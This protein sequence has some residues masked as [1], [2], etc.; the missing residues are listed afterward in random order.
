MLPSILAKQLEKGIGDYIETTFPMTNAPFKGSLRKM[1]ET[2]DSVYHEPYVSVRLPFRVAESMPTCFEAIHPAYIPYV[3]QQTAF[4]RLTGDDG[5]STLIATGTGSGKTECFLYP[6]LEYCYQHRGEPGIKALI[7]YPMNALASD[8]AKRIAELIWTSQ[9]LRGNVTAG[10]YVGGHEQIPSRMMSEDHVITDHDTMLGNPPDI[11][12]TNYKMLDYLLVRPKDAVLWKE[13]KPDTLKYIAVDELHTFDGAQG[14][15]L[16]C[17]LRRLK[18]RLFTPGGY[19]CC[20][21]TSATM[22]SKDNGK[23]ILQYAEEVFGEPFE[24]EAIVTEDRLSPDEFFVGQDITDFTMPTAEQVTELAALIDQDNEDAYLQ[25]AVTAWTDM[26]G[27]VVASPEGR[28]ALGE[29]LMHHSF[30]QS[31]ISLMKGNYHQIQNIIEELTTNYPDLKEMGDAETAV[32]ALLALISHARTGKVNHLRP[33]L[34]VQV[35]LWIRELRRLV[36]K[37]SGKEISYAIAHDLNTHQARQYLPVVNCRDCGATGW[38]S[39]LSER[40]NATINSL[41]AFYN[42]FFKAD[43]KIVMMFPHKHD[44][45][46]DGMIAGR[47]CPDCMHVKIGDDS[48]SR[49]DNCGSDMV[50]VV[51]PNPISTTGSKDH[52]QFVCPFCGSKRG[53]SLMGLRNATEISTELSQIFASKFNDD[54][55]T[56]AFSDNVQDAAHRAGFFNARTWRFGF[57]TAI[58]RHVQNGGAGLSLADFTKGFIKYWHEQFDDE[59]FVS[60]FIAPNMTWMSAYEEMIEKRKFGK[61]A[62]AKKLMGDIEKRISY[63]I[64]L[65]YGLTSRIGRT[66]EKSGCS[67]LSFPADTITEVAGV[68]HE[69]AVNEIGGLDHTETERFA[70][71]VAGYLKLMA[72]NGAF[73]DDAFS[74]FFKGNGDGYLISND[75]VSWMPGRQSGRNTP[76]FIY[77]PGEQSR[78]NYNFDTVAEK[79]YT[80]WIKSCCNEVLLE[81]SIYAAI[82]RIILEE[83]VKSGIVVS[84][85][86]TAEYTIY[87]LDKNKVFI[88]D[89]VAM[90]KCDTCGIAHAVSAENKKFWEN[91]ACIRSACAG[92]FEEDE[93]SRLDYYGKLFSSGDIVRINAREHTGLLERDD[94][95]TLEIDFKRKKDSAQVWDPNVLSC[96]PTLEMGIDIG[97][98]S[99]VILCSMPPAQSQFLQRTGR[100]GRKDGNALTLAIAAARPHDLY[101]YADPLDMIEGNVVPPKI[102]LK[103][104]AV[105]ER[106]FVA[107]CMDSWVKR[108]VTEHSIPKNVSAVLG[109][110]DSH[111]IDVFPFNFLHYV[112]NNLSHLLNSFVQLFAQYLDDTARNELRTFAQGNKLKESPMHIRIL[113]A[114]KALKKQKDSLSQSIKLLKTMVKEL[115]SKPK[116]SSYDEEIKELKAEQ[117]AL[118]NVVNEINKKDIF[119]FLSDEG[120]LPNYAFPESGIVLKAILY[121]KEDEAEEPQTRTR[122]KKSVYEYSRSASAAISEFA[123]NNSF[124]VDGRKLTIDQVDLTSAQS[125]KWRLCPNCSH[126][127]IE[128]AGKDT[129]C[130]PQCGTP[131]WADAGQVRNMLKVQMV[132]SN[133]DYT[134][135]L[136]SDESDD[137][138][139]VFYCKQLLVD[140]DE[141]HDISSAYE[142]DNEDF[143]FGY[144]FVKKATLREI[145]FGESDLVGEKLMVSGIEEVRKGFKICKYCGK[146]Q[147]EHGKDVHTFYCRTRRMQALNNDPFEE[148][149]FLY[150]EF[151]TEALRILIP[152]TTMDAS[153]VRTESFTAAFMLGMKEYFGN[154][155]HLRATVCEVPVPDADYRKQYLVIYDSVPGGTGY[156]KQLMNEQGSLIDIFE[157][158]LQKLEQCSCKED[159]QK[160]GC[161]HCLYAYRQSQNIGNISRSTAIR[162]LKSILSGKDNLTKIEK[163][164]SIPVN[165]L[166]ESELE[167]RFV[168]ALAQMG[169]EKRKVE[170]TK[171]LIND[172]E[173]YILKVNDSS[174][175]IEPQ[176]TLGP[177]Q[178]VSV[179]CKPDFI[180][181]QIGRSDKLPV[182]IFTDGFIYHKD[183]VADDT[184]KREAIR[185][186]GRYRVWTLSWR[187]VQSV[188]H[189]QVDYATPTLTYEK[190]PSGARMYQRIVGNAD[191]LK[192]GKVPAFE[193]LMQYLDAENA[194]T[195][196]KKH[197][198]AYSFSILD[199]ARSTNNLA[200]MDW[201]DTVA[202]ANRQVHFT[203]DTFVHPGTFFGSWIP[204]ST[205]AHFYAYAGVLSE[206]LQEDKNTSISVI[207]LL[208]DRVTN[209]TDKYEQEWNGFWQFFNVMQFNK[210]FVAVCGT[211]LDNHAYIAL[212]YGQ[213]NSSAEDNM[214]T[215]NSG[216]GWTEIREM[217]FDE[218]TVKIANILEKKGISAPEEAGYELANDSG[219]VIAEIELVWIKRKIGYMTE[220][221]QADRDK[222]EDAGWKIFTNV[223]EI[224]SSFKSSHQQ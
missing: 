19:L 206:R 79:K 109:K 136:I 13:N 212:P 89:D 184:L 82:C 166:F 200:F 154:V 135:S 155:D 123:P 64:M 57:R 53:L 38:T 39:I 11:L 21:G 18:S 216:E 142:M 171:S 118:V 163:L 14:T 43:D 72:Q 56:L 175:E 97:D 162:M 132:Y 172:K 193:L 104:S 36:A 86:A 202:K 151:A 121:R 167:R 190:M 137:R 111:P 50:D 213:T 80:E 217:L 75:R 7:I 73:K 204:R 158:A 44:D 46:P 25:A 224:V 115:E 133:M 35:Q 76:R 174:W 55:K 157:R 181:R 146:I 69:R 28:I 182:A 9:E 215:S 2:R 60:F 112:Q 179:Q 26:S 114:F 197:A 120:L 129:A 61:D 91:A 63:E 205:N 52:R 17:L 149:L 68:V 105:L 211:G 71:M 152:A 96:T 66:L 1:L 41:E 159:P 67:C 101:F 49:C 147:P 194:E 51:L 188:F 220:A 74:L 161:Y 54:K 140:V 128:E 3:H 165:S 199:S 62:R 45:Y 173:G 187:D 116:D 8:Q 27:M 58:Q 47:I 141:D 139:N 92:R 100:A 16:A 103:A 196:F 122:Y 169:N 29:H 107:Y 198:R 145:N 219:E 208:D 81:P 94:R 210:N 113:E 138:S 77:R 40:M 223:D 59:S 37:V 99:T 185:R 192:P 148:C 186:S 178:G 144:E 143:A 130:C 32:N 90:M 203:E 150:R 24:D 5:R 42:R 127:Q 180:I 110:L 30:M 207:A 119:N 126:A 108:G 10:M 189:A 65:E 134:K 195:L 221:Q 164:G 20:I 191:E 88:S 84:I 93:S 176:V 48:S 23:S 177:T 168:E 125:A 98:L 124:Y 131:A 22:G 160:D 156:L 85:P 12:M 170:I 15:D 222:A 201:N 31:M 218:E 183:K 33:F 214:P 4:T 6:I 117:A 153:T 209:R 95:E 87:A 78:R 34:N 102:F 106:Q 70:Q 83:L